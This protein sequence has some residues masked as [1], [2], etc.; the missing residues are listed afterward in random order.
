[1]GS[2]ELKAADFTRARKDYEDALALRNELG[3]KDNIAASRVAIAEL[4]IEEGH[5]D[6]AE[7]PAREA[8][9]EL[10]RAHKSDDQVTATAALVDALLANGKNDDAFKELGKTAPIA[11]KS[12]NLSVQ[13][14]F[15]AAKARTE[16]ASQKIGS[17]KAILKEA[18]A[19]ATKS[20]YVGYQLES[21]LALEEME[22]KS[23]KSTTSR[24][25]LEQLQKEATE[26][27]FDL[28]ARK[29]AAL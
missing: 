1:L 22:M 24:A 19:K 6:A 9:D 17:A 12:Q 14:A 7:G 10:Q 15:A 20:G 5:P 4:A 3:E 18:L 16:A 27:G 8:R 23:G 28:I 21:R 2:L 25:R 26:K 13:L 29:A 11:A